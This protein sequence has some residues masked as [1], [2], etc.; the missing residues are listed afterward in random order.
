[1]L[2]SWTVQMVMWAWQCREAKWERPP[3]TPISHTPAFNQAVGSAHG[4]SKTREPGTG[5]GDGLFSPASPCLW[6]YV[7]LH[8]AH[9]GCAHSNLKARRGEKQAQGSYPW[10]WFPKSPASHHH[11]CHPA[12]RGPVLGALPLQHSCL[13]CPMALLQFQLE[14]NRGGVGGAFSLIAGRREGV[15]GTLCKAGSPQSSLTASHG[16]GY[17]RANA[18]PPSPFCPSLSIQV[19]SGGRSCSPVLDL[20][21]VEGPVLSHKE[22]LEWLCTLF[23]C[24]EK[25]FSPCIKVTRVCGHSIIR[26]K[27]KNRELLGTSSLESYCHNTLYPKADVRRKGSN[28]DTSQREIGVSREHYQSYTGWGRRRSLPFLAKLSTYCTQMRSES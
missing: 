15:G 27:S 16:V 20:T 23:L 14:E 12:A 18:F 28:P 17:E 5:V 9:L 1:M 6:L 8:T 26:F 7:T 11:L 3:L 19:R 13:L 4:N 22:S 10:V 24:W 21:F 25:G 2:L